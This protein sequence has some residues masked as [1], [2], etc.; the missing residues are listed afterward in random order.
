VGG[1]TMSKTS[2]PTHRL[3][4][5]FAVKRLCKE[6]SPF[7]LH[8]F[9]RLRSTNDQAAAMRRRGELFAPAVVLTAN[10]IA[11]R[12]RG[13]HSW[14]SQRGC[15][16]VTFVAAAADNLKPHEIP[17][18]AGL[19]VRQAAADI[20]GRDDIR[21]KW[22]NDLVHDGRKLAGL[23]CERLSRADLIGVGLNVN[24]DR[25]GIPRDLRDRIACLS[26][27]AGREL[28]M[29]NVLIRVAAAMHAQLRRRAEHSFG[30]FVQD[31]RLY[32][33]LRGK[34]ITVLTDPAT[35]L[36]GRCEGIDD[37][38]RLLLR[39][40]GGL[41]RVVAGHILSDRG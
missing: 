12:G 6:L 16:T 34:H 38:G 33:D 41:Q 17:L 5:I 2:R 1:N 40:D 23:L 24:L 25:S 35:P 29:T 36:T 39:T 28:D 7:R 9:P 19:A 30:A 8:W 22:P 3:Q 32:D 26:D 31:Y 15:L 10:Q 20:T 14:W 18:I 37:S 13:A 11:G 4:P 27:L 21:L